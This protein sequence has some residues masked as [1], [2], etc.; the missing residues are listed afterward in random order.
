MEKPT[1]DNCKCGSSNVRMKSFK[2]NFY[3]F[4][5]ECDDCK[6]AVHDK[7]IPMQLQDSNN[8]T[9]IDNIQ[10]SLVYKWNLETKNTE[11]IEEKN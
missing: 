10:K 11:K 9:I 6:F 5:I 3:G 2:H 1:I 4:F 7:A 8:L